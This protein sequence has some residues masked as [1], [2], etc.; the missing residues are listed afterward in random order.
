[1]SEL[2]RAKGPAVRLKD[3]IEPQ[4]A[5]E[6]SIQRMQLTTENLAVGVYSSWNLSARRQ[7]LGTTCF[8]QGA[9]ELAIESGRNVRETQ[10]EIAART[11]GLLNDW[12][13]ITKVDKYQKM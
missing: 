5:V 9:I 11:L 10:I 7:E 13:A 2:F 12:G 3:V 1:M 8:F 4:Q 6:E